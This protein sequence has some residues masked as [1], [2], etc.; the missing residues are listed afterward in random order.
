M[1]QLL[2]I[3]LLGTGGRERALARNLLRSERCGRLFMQLRDVPG[4]HYADFN[5]MDFEEIARFCGQNDIHIL[6]PGPEKPIVDGLADAIDSNPL[7]PST[8]V[9]APA[10]IAAR[11]EGSK[12]F[13]KEF[14]AEEGIPS[15]RFMPVD[16]ETLHEGLSFL[17]S[18]PGPYVLKADG[19]AEGKGVVITPELSEAKDTLEEMINGLFG[20]AS[21]KVI[22]E[23]YVEGPECS[24]IIATD[25]E[26]YLILPPAR[27]YKRR[28]DGDRGPNTRGM[29]AYSPVEFADAD[30]MGKV[31]KRI[32]IPTLK[33]LK[34]RDIPY[35]GFL[36]L[37]IMNIEG[38]PILIEYNVRLGDPETQAVLPRLD[39]DFVEV[40]EGIADSTIGIKRIEVSPMASAAVVV[41]RDGRRV[42]TICGMAPDVAQAA[43]RAYADIR[44]ALM[45]GAE[46]AVGIEFR[47][48]IGRTAPDSDRQ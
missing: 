17:E 2:N 21:E 26:D 19:L 8:R 10:A 41:M 16:K 23:E 30:F 38:E 45:S 24:I 20:E 42:T 15:P 25:G 46:R 7:A 31:E 48:D 43:D 29:G 6:L 22:V 9:I 13:A 37:G 4:A 14:M 1:Q 27:D 11:L 18:L 36:Y 5:S 39:S 40:L 44:A 34:D 35:R 28:Y 33:G 12:E 47:S 3:L 32:I